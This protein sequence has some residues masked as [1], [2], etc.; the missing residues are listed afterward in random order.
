[1]A[2]KC[3]YQQFNSDRTR[4]CQEPATWRTDPDLYIDSFVRKFTWCDK[5]KHED[6][7]PIKEEKDARPHQQF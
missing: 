4:A 6:D 5:H 3:W 2:E 7:I 1:M